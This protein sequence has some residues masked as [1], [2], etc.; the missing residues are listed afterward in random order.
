MDIPSKGGPS[1]LSKK[2]F[3]FTDFKDPAS[4]FR[5]FL[6]DKTKKQ[7][8][9]K[10]ELPRKHGATYLVERGY[11][12]ETYLDTKGALAFYEEA[13]DLEPNHTQA[14]LR[15]SKALSDLT[16]EPGTSEANAQALVTRAVALAERAVELNG[17]DPL[18]HLAR[19]INLGR[20]ALYS[21]TKT[22]VDL[23]R[24]VRVGAEKAIELNKDEDLGY[25]LLGRW[26]NEMGSLSFIVKLAINVFYGGLEEG[27]HL[28]AK[29][30][31][32]KCIVLN[33]KR[34][35]H[36]IE[37]G[38]T[39]IKLNMPEKA[40]EVL[41]SALHSG[42]E[43]EDINAL[44]EKYDAEAMLAELNR[45]GAGSSSWRSMTP[46]WLKAARA[47]EQQRK[48]QSTHTIFQEET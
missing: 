36:H 47:H 26:H 45:G 33:P 17:A 11:E 1:P 39:Y 28:D 20:L 22:K 41:T 30:L 5:Q 2:P 38:R 3:H 42:M 43:V 6:T 14:L 23:V 44:H 10:V 25:H 46:Q 4:R 29:R 35:I 40:S 34:M 12:L 32:E 19:A 15:C 37:L 13:L 48:R 16:L 24:A 21:S 7:R 27:T 18:A 8:K 31:F 9:W